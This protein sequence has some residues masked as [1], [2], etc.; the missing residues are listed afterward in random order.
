MDP[1]TR[2]TPP[3]SPEPAAVHPIERAASAWLGRIT[4]DK[5][6]LEAHWAGLDRLGHAML[7]DAPGSH[8]LLR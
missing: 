4:A 7:A 5:P 6:E 8:V 1:R 2:I 3:A